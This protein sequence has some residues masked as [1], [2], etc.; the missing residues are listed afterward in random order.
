MRQ[1]VAQPTTHDAFP[2]LAAW[3][4]AALFAAGRPAS[5]KAVA[6]LGLTT[7]AALTAH[8]DH[9]L[10]FAEPAAEANPFAYAHTSPDLLRL[11]P[12]VASLPTQDP[13]IAVSLADPWP[14][15][16][17]LRR[18]TRVGYWQP[19]QALPDTPD[20]VITTAGGA[21]A[22]RALSRLRSHPDARLLELE[23]LSLDAVG[24]IAPTRKTLGR[25]SDRGSGHFLAACRYCRLAGGYPR[26]SV[27]R[28]V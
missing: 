23:P 13:L 17:L 16:F 14:L 1:T 26:D 7:F 21:P 28:F 9:R 6:W 19:G 8:A 10:V 12:L 25:G 27:R 20:L 4:I 3:A 22:D 18:E 5:F 2:L 11:A 24:R 15:P